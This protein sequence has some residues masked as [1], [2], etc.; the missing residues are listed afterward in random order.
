M[1]KSHGFTLIELLLVIGILSVLASISI[2]VYRT[3]VKD[4]ELGSASSAIFYD[5]KRARANSMTGQAGMK[6]GLHMVGGSPSYYQ[7]FSSPESFDHPSTSIESIYYLPKNII[8]T[9]PANTSTKNIIFEKIRGTLLAEE[10]VIIT[11]TVDGISKTIQI[12]SSGNVY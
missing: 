11:D 8:F 3:F 1:V 5:L 4:V 2:P 10:T 7:V 12:N 6:W 9:I